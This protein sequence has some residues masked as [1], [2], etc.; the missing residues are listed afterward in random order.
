MAIKTRTNNIH[1]VLTL[2]GEAPTRAEKIN[3]LRENNTLALR[4]VLKG[5][6]DDTIEFI[7]PKG[8]PPYTPSHPSTIPSNLMKHTSMFPYFIKGGP[9]ERLPMAKLERMFIQILEGIE[10]ADADVIIKMKDKNLEGSY[11]GIT[12]KLVTEAFPGLIHS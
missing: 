9:G 7:L 2:A 10:A 1:E 6:Y 11:K 3:L 4:D 5:A 8:A 12:K